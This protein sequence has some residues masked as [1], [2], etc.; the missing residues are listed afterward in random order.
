MKTRLMTIVVA[1]LMLSSATT[2]L[3]QK[4]D[5]KFCKTFDDYKNQTW[6]PTSTIITGEGKVCEL[7]FTDN[8][9]KFRTRDKAADK[10]LKK[11]ALVVSYAGHLYVNC[12]N[13]D[14][15]DFSLDCAN[16]AQAFPYDKDKLLF[17][18]YKINDGALLASLAL[19]VA[20]L[21]TPGIGGRALMAGSSVVWFSA[22]DL[23]G[24]RLYLLENSN[25]DGEA[26]VRGLNDEFMEK[27]LEGDEALMKQY[28]VAT[29]KNDRLSASH[30][31]PILREKGLVNE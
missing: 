25:E 5:A 31:L 30:I 29:K 13:L 12:R 10:V 2:A 22:K 9:F 23:K 20:G 7:R 1:M 18:A 28:K 8:E 3:P 14:C 24:F 16:Y 11:E 19:D 26:K 4:T 21:A 15:D 6:T 17:A 27:L